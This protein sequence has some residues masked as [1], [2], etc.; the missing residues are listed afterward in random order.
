[1]YPLWLKNQ[2]GTPV[3]W[4]LIPAMTHSDHGNLGKSLILLASCSFHLGLPHRE[5]EELHGICKV[6]G[7]PWMEDARDMPGLLLIKD[8]WASI[9]SSDSG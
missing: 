2:T 7:D 6:L 9:S 1:M 3:T 4:I 5:T 8:Q